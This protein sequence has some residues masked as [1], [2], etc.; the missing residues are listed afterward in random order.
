MFAGLLATAALAA[1]GVNSNYA[2]NLQ[3]GTPAAPVSPHPFFSDPGWG[4]GAQPA[5]IVDGYRSCD[6]S[7]GWNCGLAFTGGD[8]NWGGQACG[9]RQA[10]IDFYP[11][12]RQI[13]AVKI[14]HHGDP[15]VPKSY[16]IQTLTNGVWTTQISQT[17]N[18]QA[19]C[20]RPPGYDPALSWTCTITDE[21]PPVQANRVR[22][23]FNNCPAA[24]TSIVPGVP[25]KHGW[26]YEFEA[27]R[28][29]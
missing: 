28:L 21:F 18:N 20:A 9:V 23:V 7:L 5:E 13:S 15:H 27:Y 1:D 3:P 8:S 2:F 25:V 10:T 12:S 22:Y 6:G 29:P 24:N 4:G 17:S 26:I 11:Y 16:Q 14:T 19:R